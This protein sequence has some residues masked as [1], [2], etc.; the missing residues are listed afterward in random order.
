[1]FDKIKQFIT[2]NLFNEAFLKYIGGNYTSY[3]ANNKT[4]MEKGYNMNPDVYACISQMATKTVS[5]PYF[6]KK[7]DDKE[8]YR[9]LKHLDLATKGNLSLSQFI[10]RVKLET[11]AYK[12]E[13]M[14]FPME[15]PNELQTWSD[16]WFLYKVYM[17]ITGNCYF[18][19]M[20]PEEGVNKGVPVQLYVLPAHLVQIIIKDKAELLGVENP[21]KEYVLIEGTS[22]IKFPAEQ[23][24][25]FKFPNPNFDFNGEH[26]YGMSPLRA[27]LRNI[28][29]QNS[30]IDLGIQTLQNGGAFGFI[31]GKT[32]PLS[33]EQAQSLK[34][35][36]TEMQASSAPLGRIAGSSA[37]VGFTRISLTADELKP[38]MYLDWDRKTIC[39]VLGWSDELL[40]NDGKA[41]LG[42]SDTG[43]ARK[44][45][46][47]DNIQPDLKILEEGL[48]SKFLPRF[49]GYENTVIE[50][51]ISELPEMQKDMKEMAETLNLLPLKPNEIRTAFKYESL[52]DE[53]MDIV[54]INSGKQRIDDY[55]PNDITQL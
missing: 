12:D 34:D 22:F 31:H 10:K 35:R 24:I 5:V 50:W 9:K 40:N 29:S 2:R 30:A 13:E 28:N 3:D 44:Q 52:D 16:I 48:N 7:I 41:R 47:T 42:S 21:I 46:V 1:M 49:K 36:L 51:D 8:Q 45:V 27:A 4:Y 37:E 54:W 33:P 17:R 26:L 53:G 15:R 43:E 20:A 6:V 38:F 19:M 18:Y 11:K 25:H 55:N 39:N 14:A 23:I 32:S